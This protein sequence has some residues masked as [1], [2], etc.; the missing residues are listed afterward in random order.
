MRKKPQEFGFG[1]REVQAA[2]VNTFS[3]EVVMQ[4]QAARGAAV[5]KGLQQ[6]SQ[7]LAGI[8]Q[9][10]KE[11]DD[12]TLRPLAQAVHNLRQQDPT[13]SDA[14]LEK[15]VSESGLT[16]ARVL[17]KIRKSGGFD[18]F[19]APEFRILYDELK[20]VSA[21][22][23][24]R[25]S[26]DSVDQTAQ[27][28]ASGFGYTQN[29][30]GTLVPDDIEVLRADLTALYQEAHAGNRK[31]L[32]GP[33]Q[34]GVYDSRID[35][36]VQKHVEKALTVGRR[37][38][39]VDYQN[40]LVTEL[41]AP[42]RELL[43]GTED[44]PAATGVKIAGSLKMHLNNVPAL[45]RPKVL[46]AWLGNLDAQLDLFQAKSPVHENQGDYE[47]VFEAVEAALDSIPESVI[48]ASP[49]VERKLDEVQARYI[50]SDS[51]VERLKARDESFKRTPPAKVK[52]RAI[53]LMGS[54]E[55]W[56]DTKDVAAALAQAEEVQFS[57]ATASDAERAALAEKYGV[58]E[59]EL[60]VV[61]AQMTEVYQNRLDRLNG[62]IEHQEALKIRREDQDWTKRSRT[63]AEQEHTKK[64]RSENSAEK[65][66]DYN[67]MLTQ[68]SQGR[69]TEAIDQLMVSIADDTELTKEDRAGLMARATLAQ[70]QDPLLDQLKQPGQNAVG[71]VVA[72]LLK[73]AG[74]GETPP[75]P[76]AQGIL[77]AHVGTLAETISNQ[78]FGEEKWMAALQSGEIQSFSE[79]LRERL[80][81]AAEEY[82]YTTLASDAQAEVLGAVELSSRKPAGLAT[83]GGMEL[84]TDNAAANGAVVVGQAR[85]RKEGTMD[86]YDRLVSASVDSFKD[87]QTVSPT[88]VSGGFLRTSGLTGAPELTAS[89]VRLERALN[90]YIELAEE[91][92]ELASDARDAMRRTLFDSG[93]ISMG[94]PKGL[95][96][97]NLRTVID[98]GAEGY[99]LSEQRNKREKKFFETLDKAQEVLDSPLYFD[100]LEDAMMFRPR[101]FQQGGR[102]Y[103]LYR[104]TTDDL[105]IDAT[106]RVRD[107]ETGQT[108]TWG[109]EDVLHYTKGF[110][111]ETIVGVP[112]DQ[113]TDKFAY[114]YLYAQS[115]VVTHHNN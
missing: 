28:L 74:D 18:A 71:S 12:S 53:G 81:V 26:L 36:E 56:R 25:V 106:F 44:S 91:G 69:N 41:G 51:E 114:E 112:A 6:L 78:M 58:D 76:E 22:E 73:Q 54:V 113:I 109:F 85:T 2:P 33:L 97:E 57:L 23:D 67:L 5:G 79:E 108:I 42:V 27:N 17:N 15:A 100:N 63:I 39:E 80:S 60:E 90:N 4:P 16:T 77:H 98:K 21:F 20:G 105:N 96:L 101:E 30:D 8:G 82:V 84:T 7:T 88:D 3:P 75:S 43:D 45:D 35:G 55:S 102:F 115:T 13:I 49:D 9:Q 104:S 92:G 29:P 62:D 19:S 32:K 95:M 94:S 64:L 11:F 89:G 61:S 14:D 110:L 46:V 103:G 52:T 10:N 93:L 72:G 50:I 37:A 40:R 70:Q 68:Q 59:D 65:V 48:A 111:R 31:G 38:Q 87:I 34:T 107:A 83:E 1:V 47:D 86:Q 66:S 24:A 99:E